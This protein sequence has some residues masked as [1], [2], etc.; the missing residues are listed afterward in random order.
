MVSK[1]KHLEDYMNYPGN[2]LWQRSCF[3]PALSKTLF[4]SEK[5]L[6]AK[7]QHPHYTQVAHRQKIFGIICG[8]IPKSSPWADWLHVVRLSLCCS[9]N[10]ARGERAGWENSVSANA[11]VSSEALQEEGPIRNER[12]GDTICWVGKD[13]RLGCREIS[14]WER[15][16]GR[17]SM[18]RKKETLGIKDKEKITW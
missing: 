6:P 17:D 12:V 5:R 11:N 9:V 3:F 7:H 13:V 10:K 1:E 2:P 15:D 14:W 16:K 8:K 4:P 18:A